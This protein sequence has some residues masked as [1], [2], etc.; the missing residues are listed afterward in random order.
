MPKE[1]TSQKLQLCAEN[2]QKEHNGYKFS[3]G[4]Q[5]HQIFLL[6]GLDKL[7]KVV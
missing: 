3:L 6:I 4:F 2:I 7:K 1:R 5:S